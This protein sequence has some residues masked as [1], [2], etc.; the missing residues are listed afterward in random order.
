M[1]SIVMNQRQSNFAEQQ[2]V[3]RNARAPRR[4]GL[5]IHHACDCQWREKHLQADLPYL[6]RHIVSLMDMVHQ[7]LRRAPPDGAPRNWATGHVAA[8]HMPIHIILDESATK[9]TRRRMLLSVLP[10]SCLVHLL[11]FPLPPHHMLNH[12]RW[13]FVYQFR[14]LRQGDM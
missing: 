4:Q 5:H 8:R 14:Q 11:Q 2:Y 3:V 7:I 12:R 6:P 10:F 13:P 9:R 1:H